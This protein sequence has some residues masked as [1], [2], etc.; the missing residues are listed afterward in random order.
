MS[1][2]LYF[3]S[4]ISLLS[5][6]ISLAVSPDF[7]QDVFFL[8]GSLPLRPL[9]FPPHHVFFLLALLLTDIS[10]SAS[11]PFTLWVSLPPLALLAS[12][13]LA[14]TYVR[15]PLHTVAHSYSTCVSLLGV[16][17]GN[18]IHLQNS[19]FYSF[20]FSLWLKVL[21]FSLFFSYAA[22]AV[23]VNVMI[24]AYIYTWD[25]CWLHT[26][27][28]THKSATEIVFIE[29]RHLHSQSHWAAYVTISPN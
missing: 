24:C 15:T 14:H 28:H 12:P 25:F 1:L 8:S 4:I 27:A 17:W 10:L 7:H 26:C 11:P 22:L 18:Q 20:L 13:L 23:W 29:H 21:F 16:V 5:S 9:F 2:F 3:L 19:S 6:V